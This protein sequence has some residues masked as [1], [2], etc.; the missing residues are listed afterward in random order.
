MKRIRPLFAVLI[1]CT[2]LLLPALGAEDS[3]PSVWAH[4]E[5]E[6]A[7][8]RSFVPQELQIDYQANITRAEFARVAM[9]FVIEQYNYDKSYFQ[10]GM[11]Y[12]DADGNPVSVEYGVFSD[13]RD[14][15][16]DWAYAFG[17]VEG[18]GDGTFDP[19]APIT[20]QEAAV[21]L[22]RAYTVYAG[23]VPSPDG[24]D[25]FL[26]E[27]EIAPWARESVAVINGWG[28]MDGR[29][30]GTFDPSGYYTREQCFLT[31]LRLYQNG[32]VSRAKGNVPPLYSFEEE[33]HN[34]LY[35]PFA[36][37]GALSATY[38]VDTDDYTVLYGAIWGTS[39]LAP[40]ELYVVSRSGGFRNPSMADGT[41]PRG[42]Y[43]DFQIS[44]DFKTLTFS[45]DGVSYR[46][47][48]ETSRL[49]QGPVNSD[50]VGLEE[51]LEEE[52]PV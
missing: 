10:H 6:E 9:D 23:D 4:E 1:V 15:D 35:P 7:I 48:L 40:A 5:V 30:D 39:H 26:D 19:D 16:V 27:D 18:R 24:T 22:L 45:I 29:G 47:D 33:I 34:I 17:I 38:R 51:K 20:R 28:V 52:E 49:R 21:M 43:T 36:P 50:E 13:T 44:P 37:G 14:G 11:Y 12:M 32:P 41:V 42:V 25:S 3:G 46:C 8:E 2:L 31:I